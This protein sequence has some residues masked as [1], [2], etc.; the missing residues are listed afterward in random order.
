M[1]RWLLVLAVLVLCGCE[2]SARS[3][4]LHTLSPRDWQETLSARGE[5]VSG[6]LTALN[7]PGQGFSQRQVL[8]MVA[9]GSRVKKGD[10]IAVF[11]A[12]AVEKELSVLELDLLRNALQRQTQQAQAQINAAQLGTEVAE[13]DGQLALSERYANATLASISKNELLDKLQDLGYLKN[14]RSTLDW[15][16]SQL[17]VRA[18][19]DASVIAAQR[20]T[21]SGSAEQKRGSLQALTLLAPHDGVLRLN[22]NW[23]GSKA[24][25]G[26]SV[27]A[28]DDFANL[29]D[30]TTLVA[31]FS[32][33]Q[34]SSDS[35]KVGQS[36]ALRVAGSG[37]TLA[38]TVSRVSASASV[39]NR[40]S[41]VKYIEFEAT[42]APDVSKAMA[43]TPGQAVS[44]RVLTVDRK[45]ALT[46]PNT[47][48][49]T[50]ASRSR[51]QLDD[52]QIVD[53]KLGEQ[54]A[55]LSE[56]S[57]GVAAGTRIRLN[58]DR[59]AAAETKPAP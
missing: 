13:V 22:S 3:H 4:A 47:A 35:L 53:V 48:L 29:P 9:D 42:I 56:I 57:S 34:A 6:K 54:G 15:R 44:A 32:I 46:V 2:E 49:L 25:V 58:P 14:R 11:Q 27:W 59:S 21:L 18:Q 12:R 38:S 41:P 1:S 16:E 17:S 19:A 5:I 39:R 28:G 20:A 52:G 7:V 23:D 10:V 33:P 40:E 30:F 50:D 55:V 43:L 37:Q 31:R 51:V 45:Q 36:V 8:Q 24:Q 26:A